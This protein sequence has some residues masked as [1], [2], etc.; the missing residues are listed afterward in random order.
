MR[1]C[2]VS[3]TSD[4]TEFRGSIS[5]IGPSKIDGRWCEG[6]VLVVGVVIGDIGGANFA[7]V[8]IWKNRTHSKQVSSSHGWLFTIHSKD[9]LDPR[10]VLKSNVRSDNT[11]IALHASHL[12]TSVPQGFQA[13]C[14]V[15]FAEKRQPY[16]DSSARDHEVEVSRERLRVFNRECGIDP[17]EHFSIMF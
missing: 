12:C 15:F 6:R 7:T 5:L 4:C 10:Y 3:S 17:I 16:T 14:A 11:V 2:F 1:L 13:S 8:I 9:T